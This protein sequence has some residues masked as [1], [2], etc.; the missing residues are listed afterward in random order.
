MWSFKTPVGK[1]QDELEV[2][3]SAGKSNH[4]SHA[5][6]R[7]AAPPLWTGTPWYAIF[8]R[9]TIWLILIYFD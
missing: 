1:A 2:C 9:S 4:L 3:N 7:E 6:F 5:Y 8:V